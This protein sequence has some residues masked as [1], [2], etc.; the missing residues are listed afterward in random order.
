MEKIKALLDSSSL[1]DELRCSV[2]LDIYTEPQ[3]LPCGHNFCLQCL[4]KL[5]RHSEQNYISCPEC[6]ESHYYSNQWQKNFKLASI[7]DGFRRRRHNRLF[8]RPLNGTVEVCCDYCG[9]DIAGDS[10]VTST[11]VMTCLKCEVSMCTEHAQHHLKLPAF[12][13][14][15]LVE[16][17][18]D[19]MQRKCSEHDER[20]RY[21]CMKEHKL[22]CSVCVIWG[23]HSHHAVR[24]LETTMK[25]LQE[26]LNTQLR[27]V[28]QKI[29]KTDIIVQKQ[30]KSQQQNK[31]YMSFTKSHRRLLRTPLFQ[32]QAVRMDENNIETQMEKNMQHFILD[33]LDHIAMFID[34][35]CAVLNERDEEGV[36]KDET[37][38]EETE[39]EETEEVETADEETDEEVNSNEYEHD[40][41]NTNDAEVREDTSDDE[42]VSSYSDASF[43]STLDESF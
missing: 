20:F 29:K 27:N 3:L 35:V 40:T 8:S 7:V 9:L 32:P 2:C 43:D 28:N 33:L 19:L 42:E 14:H 24:T 17:I 11:A 22:L 21:Y 30:E 26:S 13:K 36:E 10:A 34:T 15:P 6:R 37:A 5:K 31:E 38:E 18:N 39:E 23:G 41:N 12:R 25:E 4:K 16:P 1:E